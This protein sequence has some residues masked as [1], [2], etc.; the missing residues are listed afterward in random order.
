[1]TT[2]PPPGKIRN[3][4]DTARWV[5]VYRA[6]ETERPDAVFRDPYARR[7]MGER[8]PLIIAS[9]R[10][11]ESMSWPFV[12]RTF[13]IDKF[14]TREV[15]GGCDQVI[16]LAAGLDSRPYRMDLPP[17]LAWVEIDLAEIIEEKQEILRNEMPR[18]R[19]ERIVLDL[20]DESARRAVFA[21][22]G[23]RAKRTLIITE[24]L[25]VYL[26]REQV[27]SLADDL[28]AMPGAS[29]W[30]TDLSSPRLLKMLDKTMGRRVREAGAPF[31]FAPEEGPEFFTRHGWKPMDAA[32]MFHEAGRLRRLPF[33]WSLLAKLPEPKNW[34]PSRPWSGICVFDRLTE[35]TEM[36]VEVKVETGS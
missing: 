3:I 11:R 36:K 10:K 34:K 25:I 21:R 33:F 32:S 18:C 8:G 29:R 14:V 5:A 27:A 35:K 15:A 12:A 16:N 20:A 7:L 6:E 13:L 31:K 1:M 17:S 28:H 19:L 22:L 30:I 24:G 9:L 4:S 2:T 23:A 26:S